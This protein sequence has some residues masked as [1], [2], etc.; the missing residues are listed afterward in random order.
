MCVWR[1]CGT[2]KSTFRLLAHI[3]KSYTF[4]R[5]TV[6]EEDILKESAGETLARVK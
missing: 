3:S 1:N 4:L 5:L 6:S 2:V